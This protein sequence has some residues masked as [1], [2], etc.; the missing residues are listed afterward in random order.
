MAEDY[1]KG[2]KQFSQE[3]INLGKD[4]EGNLAKKQELEDQIKGKDNEI[5]KIQNDIFSIKSELR[6]V[7]M[8]LGNLETKR[9]DV[10]AEK[11][12]AN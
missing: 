2:L 9:K 1:L 12:K 10:E 7:E 3:L 4:I 8:E 6:K 5:R 11:N